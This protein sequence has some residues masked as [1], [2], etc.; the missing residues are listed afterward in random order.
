MTV[1]MR[2]YAIF[3]YTGCALGGAI[4]LFPTRAAAFQ[5][6]NILRP[7]DPITTSSGNFPG[8]EAP[9]NAIDGLTGTKY[10]N[11]DELNVF[12]TV[13][14]QYS[15]PYLLNGFSVTSANDAPERDPKTYTL[16]GSND[17]TL[18]T[19]ITSGM[20]ADF[21][22]RFETQTVSFAAISPFSFYR[23]VVNDVRDS[24]SANSVQFAEFGLRADVEFAPDISQPGDPIVSNP[25]NSPGPE[26][27]ANLIDNNVDT[28]FLNFAEQNVAVTLTPS[29]IGGPSLLRGIALTS[30]NDAP[31]RDPAS[32]VIA[33]SNNGVDFFQIYAGVAP[34]FTARFQERELFFANSNPYTQYRV[35]FVNVVDPGAANSVQIAEM[36]LIASAP[37]VVPEAGSGSLLATIGLLTLAGVVVSRRRR[38]RHAPQA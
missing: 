17:N 13:Q 30:A 7:G 26:G 12:I 21:N 34:T 16:L 27:I 36:R 11:F 8:G 29:L 19:T 37:A 35:T 25:D 38:Y 10:L 4:A 20:L 18:F 2:K 9:A 33:G 15:L 23:F 14:P 5:V 24:A 1:I 22:N 3:C 28:K 31:E 32:L 6:E